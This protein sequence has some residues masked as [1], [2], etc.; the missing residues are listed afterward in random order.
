MITANY[1]VLQDEP[2]VSA[3]MS[4]VGFRLELKARN[5]RLYQS[6]EATPMGMGFMYENSPL[7]AQ[8]CRILE[9]V[10]MDFSLTLYLRYLEVSH[11]YVAEDSSLLRCYVR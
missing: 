3:H 1:G 4:N 6:L 10:Q 8:C 9:E 2:V 11:S 7:P 5:L